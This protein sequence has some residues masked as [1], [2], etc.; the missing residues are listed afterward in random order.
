MLN[1]Q[2][3]SAS[4]QLGPLVC[5]RVA[6]AAAIV[7][8]ATGFALCGG[9]AFA[10]EIKDPPR[11]TKGSDFSSMRDWDLKGEQI[12]PHGVNSLY[13]PITPGHKHALERRDHPDGRY[14]KETVVLDTT[15][16]FD[17]RGIGKFKTSVVQEEE[18]LDGVLTQRTLNW[19]ALDRA[20]NNVYSFGEVSWNIENGKPSFTGTWR[21]GDPDG[22]GVAEPGLLMPG[23][24]KVG[25]RYIYAGGR[26]TAY[27]GAENMEDD[28]QATVPAGTF[29]GC[30]RV[31]EQDLIDLKDIS[32][33]IW[34]PEVGL[35]S[36]T[37]DGKLVVSNAL[38]TSNPASNVSSIGKLR[39]KPA[40]QKSA[41][42]KVSIAD[43]KRIALQRMPG[44]VTDVTIEKKRGK[45]VYVVEIQTGSGEVDVFVDTQTGEVVGT[46]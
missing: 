40:K 11:W 28:V 37:S 33:K 12:I 4:W 19:L 10:A 44:K 7:L 27:G 3:K 2:T 9:T 32:D 18:Y 22:D 34:C 13:Y 26:S 42:A 1:R 17:I 15:E 30:V 14:R 43:A 25:E 29:K 16:D 35:V 8:L 41:A 6:R 21:A 20:T 36:D 23:T 45:N 24:F 46:D 5:L 38:P 31:R 39:D